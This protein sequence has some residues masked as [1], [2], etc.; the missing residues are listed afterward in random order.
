MIKFSIITVTKNSEETIKDTLSSVSIQRYSN[1]EH[2]IKDGLSDDSTSN[3]VKSYLSNKI[4]LISKLDL[5]IYDAMNQGY[6][7]SNGDVIAFLNSDDFYADDLVL[8]DVAKVFSNNAIDYVYGNVVMVN[9]FG[10]KIR[11][12]DMNSHL[13]TI[14]NMKQ[15]AHPALFIRRRCLDKLSPCFDTSYKISADLKQQLILIYKLGIVGAYIPRVLAVV[16]LGGES[17]RNINSYYLG[18]R[19]SIKAYNEV[20]EGGGLISTI[21]KVLI[22]I[23]YF[24]RKKE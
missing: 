17:T 12:W 6:E 13:S 11:V 15:I 14:A 8:E 7:Y 1:L 19:E 10:E 24:I 22:K 5:G 23:P 4:S 9:K 2:I 18:W 20:F 21:K 16:R 3:I